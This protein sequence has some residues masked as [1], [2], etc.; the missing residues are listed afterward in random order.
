MKKFAVLALLALFTLSFGVLNAQEVKLTLAGWSSNPAEDESLNAALAAFTEETGIAVEFTP[1][2]DHTVTMQNAF[3][4][5]TYPQVFYVDS[6]KLPD[7]AEAGVLA[8]GEDFIEDQEGF[9]QPLLDIFTYDG[10]LY[11][12]PKDF[13]TM[14]L[15]YN[16]D[17]FDAAGLEYPTADWTWDDL[18]AA[19]EALTDP[20]AGVIGLVLPPELPRWLPFLYQA[21][22]GILDENGEFIFDSEETLTAIEYY[23]S[24][25][26]EGIGG[27]PSSV[28]SG[29]GGEA[30]GKGRAAM[31]MEGNWVIQFLLDNYPE[32]NWGVAELPAGPAGKATMAFT[33]C[34]GVAKDNDY[35]EESWALVNYLTNEAGAARVATS[36]FGPMP[37]RPSA[38]ELYLETWVARAEGSKL[39]AEELNAFVAGG[40]YSK[41]WL[42]PVGWQP[43]A[44]TFNAALQRAFNG[45]LTAQDVLDET[46]A[47]AEE[48]L[49]Q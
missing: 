12:P 35:P 33:V 20:D 39:N 43:F 28:D 40:E 36:S 14:A 19:A 34:Y 18:K 48:L 26:T 6:F 9:Y 2:T 22:G 3:A 24:F 49:D 4:S 27:T 17:L 1:S 10:V 29:W 38:A 45:E 42:L 23:L 37:T 11:C 21:G 15:Q 25:A 47:V 31:A 44:D 16:K 41:P 8:E 13:S 5:G 30:F 32:L 46:V 7:W